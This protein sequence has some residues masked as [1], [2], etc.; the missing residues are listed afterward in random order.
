MKIIPIAITSVNWDV[1]IREVQEITGVSPVRILD[2][3]K[4]NI[5]DPFAYLA[6]LNSG[7]FE[8]STAWHHVSFSVLTDHKLDAR[9]DLKVLVFE[10]YSIVTGTVAQWVSAVNWY[11]NNDFLNGVMRCLRSSLFKHIEKR[12]VVDPIV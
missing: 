10:G 4:I 6:T 9:I 7:T 11:P 1:F 2:D 12:Y 5:K 3:K 8:R